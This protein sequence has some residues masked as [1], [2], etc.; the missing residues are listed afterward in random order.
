MI[1][2][3]VHYAELDWVTWCSVLENM[4]KLSL[5][6]KAAVCFGVPW[7]IMKNFEIKCCLCERLMLE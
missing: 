1:F 6:V 7:V 5:Q 3:P 2:F 4:E